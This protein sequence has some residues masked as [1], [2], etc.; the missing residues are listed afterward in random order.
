MDY[1]AGPLHLNG[2]ADD[3]TIVV[4]DSGDDNANVG[5]YV[6]DRVTGLDMVSTG[7]IIFDAA[8]D[9]TIQLGAQTQGDTFYVPSTI[10]GLTIKL[11]T[12]GGFDKVYVGTT[13]GNENTGSLDAIQGEFRIDGGAPAAQDE[14]YFND[15]ANTVGQTYTVSNELEPVFTLLDGRSW[16]YDTTT[17]HRS[18]MHDI[19]YRRMETVVLNAGQGDDIIDLQSTHR[20]QDPNGGKNSTFTVNAGPGADTIHLGAPVGGG[21]SLQSFDISHDFH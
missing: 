17:V 20:E 14:L 19:F 21:F 5:A 7:A 3:D 11:D 10:A 2:E 6:G 18:G 4:D 15:Q 8:D 9:I 12:G 16:A 1:I 13:Q